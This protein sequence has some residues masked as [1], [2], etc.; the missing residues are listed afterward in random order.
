MSNGQVNY[1][2]VLGVARNASQSE[3]KSAYRRLAKDKHPDSPNGDEREFER[4]REAYEVLSNADRR[5]EH[6]E[7]LDLAFAADQLSDLEAQFSQIEQDELAAK[8]REKEREE[9]GP[10][11]GERMRERLRS[12]QPEPPQRSR[13]G[14]QQ[15]PPKWHELSEFDPDPITLRLVGLT[16][17][18]SMIAFVIVGQLGHWTQG[19]DVPFFIPAGISFL[20]PLMPLAY[21]LTGLV[22]TYFAFRAAGYAAVGLVFVSA[23]VVAGSGAPESFLQF[24]ILGLGVILVLIYLGNRRS[25]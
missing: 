7:A 13:R 11:F 1:Y 8:R 25:R 4:V 19:T 9:R 23:L 18:Y 17:L 20:A 10:S 21:L 15:E 12:S 14:R 3:I 5:G 2:D 24:T 16:F 6:N 22:A